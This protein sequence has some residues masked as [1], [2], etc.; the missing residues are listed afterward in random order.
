MGPIRHSGSMSN[1]REPSS[2]TWR[3]VHAFGLPGG[4]I[5]A[6][7]A[8]A[9]FGSVWARLLISPG[10]QLPEVLQ[11]MMFMI[12]GHYFA[13]RDRPRAAASVPGPNP[14]F[15]PLGVIRTI[16]VLGF[17]VCAAVLYR[18][19]RLALSEDPTNLNPGTLTLVLVGGFMLGVVTTRLI[20]I[21]LGER[22]PPRIIED[23]RAAVSITAAG[24]LVLMFFD[25]WDPARVFGAQHYLIEGAL[26]SAVGFYFG[27][28]S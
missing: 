16:F 3:D 9:I 27:A 22:R 12:L 11:N 13:S 5:R 20:G 8:L 2:P 19:G 23:L 17:A 14:L 4:S 26:T 18:Q 6:L 24:L 10:R 28:R 7:L 15:L 25:V 21:V 1:P